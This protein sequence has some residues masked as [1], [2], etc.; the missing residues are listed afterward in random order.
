M[1]VARRRSN[2]PI[3]FALD[4][5]GDKWS[6]LIIRDIMFFN[7]STYGDFLKSDEKI[8]TNI[9]ADRLSMLECAGL[10][11][12][13]AML[14][15]KTKKVYK[16]TQKSIDLLPAM[17]EIVKWSSTY[18]KDTGAPREFV[19]RVKSDREKFI[20]EYTSFLKSKHLE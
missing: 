19:E 16:L 3:A 5:W 20:S 13:E 4:I 6:L 12:S 1:K 2:C 11:K 15:N 8:S 10:L 14:N 7:K 17:I 18:D 9:L